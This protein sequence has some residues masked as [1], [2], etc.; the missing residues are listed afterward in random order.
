MDLLS[1]GKFLQTNLTAEMGNWVRGPGSDFFDAI[2]SALGPDLPIIA[3]DLGFITQHVVDLRDQYNFP[4]MKVLQFAFSGPENPFLP[5]SYQR[6]CVVYT[7]THDN[8]TACGWYKSAK[9]NEKLFVRQYLGVD[10]SDIA[11]DLIRASWK[12]TGVFAIAPMQDTLSLDSK[13]RFNYPS[14][15]GGNWEWRVTESQ[16]TGDIQGRLR[17]VCWLYQ[18]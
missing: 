15:L 16:L 7:G 1:T 12:S 5:H 6:N 2:R 14:R 4:G 11:W 10:G 13:A 17:E 18:R 9:E 8:D 3:E